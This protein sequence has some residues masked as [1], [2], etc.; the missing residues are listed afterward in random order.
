MSYDLTVLATHRNELLLA[1]AA[2]WLHNLGKLSEEFLRYQADDP[3]YKDFDYQAIVGTVADWWT[4]N[5]TSLKRELREAL[6][7]VGPAGLEAKTQ[8]L[9]HPDERTWLKRP[10]LGL[11]E[12]LNDRVYALGDFIEFQEYDWYKIKSYGRRID[13]VFPGGALATELL[14]AAHNAAS[15]IEKEGTPKGGSGV[16]TG[17][18][19]YKSDAFGEEVVIEV[20]SLALQRRGLLEA[21]QALNRS[22]A[23]ASTRTVLLA[24]VGDTRRPINEVTL[25]DLSAAVAA[26]YKAAAA[27][28][29][30]ERKWTA[31]D[32]LKWR[33]LRVAVDGFGFYSQA[34]RLPDLLTRQSA[35]TTVLDQLRI[36]LEKTYP[37]GNEVYRDETGSA[38][39]VPD[40]DDDNEQGTQIKGLI[41]AKVQQ[42][43]ERSAIK[44]EILPQITVGPPDKRGLGLADQLKL[45]TPPPQA[46]PQ[47]VVHWWQS[48]TADICPVCGL[49]PQ[50]PP[51]TKAGQRKVCEICERRRDDRA[52]TWASDLATTIWTD[53]VADDNGRLALVVGQFGLEK[54]LDGTLVQT[55]TVTDPAQDSSPNKANVARK[56]PSFARIRRV[57]ETTRAFWQTALDEHRPDGGPLL[58]QPGPRLAIEGALHPTRPGDT[59][60]PFHTYE[61]LVNGIH[62]SVVWDSDNRRFITCD[63]LDYLAK[64]GQ[65]GRSVEQVLHEAKGQRRSVTVEEPV[66]YGG[67]NKKW[68]EITVESVS[69]LPERYVPAIPILAEPRTFMALAPAKSALAVVKAIKAK[70]EREMG[71]VRNRLPLTLGVV[72]AGRRTPLAALLDA[73]RRMLR[74]PSQ[75]LQPEVRE[76]TPQ[77]PL[78]DGWPSK[79]DVKLRLGER[80]IVVGVPTVMG[81]NTTPDVWY[82]YWQAAGKP[83]D[84]NRWFI[85]PGGEHWVHVC[86]LRPGDTVTSTP[87][88]F[89]FEYLDVSARRFEVAYG[90]DGQ[91]LGNDN[92]QRPYLL[93]QLAELEDTWEQVRHLP[94]SQIK[95]LEA[96][97]EAKRRDWGEP[98]GTLNVSPTFK[99]FV[100]DVLREAQVYTPALEQAAITGLLA[101]AL[102][103]HLTIHKEKA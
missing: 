91:R 61:L 99:R 68:G 9:L 56:N 46:D 57:W 55:L 23:L 85:G 58:P 54:W 48:A 13:A 5:K 20:S 81:D 21:I 35:L 96:L 29:V 44:G 36:L 78:P 37:L 47:E 41:E 27:K 83:T 10:V 28:L 34:P 24:T 42:V 8:A 51:N 103:I 64:P 50:A 14:E 82:P 94:T 74:R 49:R 75:V 77:N 71:K 38:F 70:Y 53:E 22:R 93:E 6:K 101:D 32:D 59:L 33:V 12:P 80:E 25:W 30:L 72:Y 98:I 52:K 11:P 73:G 39:L 19:T 66:G 43:F 102:E 63:N 16:Q 92:R 3:A 17:T 45:R 84:R 62:I 69:E 88:T 95:G 97:I 90:D 65:L 26:F 4:A 89:D 18:D 100:G 2:A 86:D 15:G 76:L 67:R 7:D 79:L 1:E 40:L 87:S 31:R 60:G